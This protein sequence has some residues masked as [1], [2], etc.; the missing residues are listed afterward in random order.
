MLNHHR[1]EFGSI[2]LSCDVTWFGEF[3]PITDSRM[4]HAPE[5]VPPFEVFGIERWLLAEIN[6]SCSPQGPIQTIVHAS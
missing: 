4:V 5:R 6:S 3:Q 1:T 2:V